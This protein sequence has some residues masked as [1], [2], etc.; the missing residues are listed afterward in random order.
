VS[1]NASILVKSAAAGNCLS[2]RQGG[3]ALADACCTKEESALLRASRVMAQVADSWSCLCGSEEV[4]CADN[5]L[6]A[7]P[8]RRAGDFLLVAKRKSPKKRRPPS[9]RNPEGEDMGEARAEL[10]PR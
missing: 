1:K 8:A 5:D 2:A 7:G 6:T 3:M 9:A 4:R 10:A